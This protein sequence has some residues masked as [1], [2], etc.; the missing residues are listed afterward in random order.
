MSPFYLIICLILV[1][2]SGFMSA[3]EIAIFSLSRFQIR[4]LKEN[5]GPAKR[6][7]K[8]LISDPAGL[9]IITLVVNEIV[10][11]SL[12]TIITHAV[13]QNDLSFLSIPWFSKLPEW[14]AQIL[15]GTLV[16]APIVLIFCE[17]TPKVIA[18][19]ANHI[20]APLTVGPLMFIYDM[21]KPMR[22]LLQGFVGL[23]SKKLAVDKTLLRE[24][25]FLVMVEEGHKE[26]TVQLSEMELIRSVFDLDDTPVSE[27][28][29]PFSKVYSLPVHMTLQSALNALNTTKGQKFSRIPVVNGPG[30]VVGILYSKDLLVAKLEKEDPNTPISTIMGRT[31][32][33]NSQLR[34]NSLFRKMKKQKAHMAIVEDEKGRAI[35]IATMTDVLDALFEELLPDE[36]PAPIVALPSKGQI[37][38]KSK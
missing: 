31:F 21:L 8:R 3:S 2:I 25:D 1:A 5:F 26:G 37:K 29:T 14:A 4:A 38:A 36:K 20:V 19:R 11:V 6:K 15:I 17:I 22:M 33:I 12:S 27:V 16:T 35:G 34:L 18:A 24:E 7:I 9:L 32:T 10:N 28:F 13:S 30:K 23:L